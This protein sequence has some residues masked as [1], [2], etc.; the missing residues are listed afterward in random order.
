LGHP[1]QTPG[2]PGC[3]PVWH[4]QG[5]TS[6][7]F[8]PISLAIDFVSSVSGAAAFYAPEMAAFELPSERPAPRMIQRARI[9]LDEPRSQH[10]RWDWP[11]GLKLLCHPCTSPSP[12]MRP[13]G[14][15]RVHQIQAPRAVYQDDADRALRAAQ[16]MIDMRLTPAADC[17][18][19]SADKGCVRRYLPGPD[20]EMKT[21]TRTG[22]R[23]FG[24]VNPPCFSLCS[25]HALVVIGHRA[26]Q[27]WRE[28]ASL[29]AGSIR[30]AGFALRRIHELRQA[31]MVSCSSGFGASRLPA[32]LH[33]AARRRWWSVSTPMFLHR[34]QR[35]TGHERLQR[36]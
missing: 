4:G 24:E 27:N 17:P 21:A 14:L 6:F 34:P 33:S 36:T 29:S 13:T 32:R 11:L 12:S 19:D 22:P 5:V 30:C 15:A 20:R 7:R 8:V 18:K 26:R 10:F 16:N 31:R 28:H 35:M 25:A 3:P 23:L 1:G 9:R 2:N